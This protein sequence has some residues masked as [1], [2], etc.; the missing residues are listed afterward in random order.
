[1]NFA[2]KSKG[3]VGYVLKFDHILINAIARGHALN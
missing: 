1:M 2:G 3:A